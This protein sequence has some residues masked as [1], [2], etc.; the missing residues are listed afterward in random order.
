MSRYEHK[1]WEKLRTY[2]RSDLSAYNWVSKQCQAWTWSLSRPSRIKT[3]LRIFRDPD[4]KRLS[5]AYPTLGNSF[6]KARVPVH[7]EK[8][9]GMKEM[10]TNITQ[11]EVY[12]MTVSAPNP[13]SYM[14]CQGNQKWLWFCSKLLFAA[15]KINQ[16]VMDQVFRKPVSTYKYNERSHVT[17]ET[18]R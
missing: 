10:E 18:T 9:G 16:Y 5:A 14:I 8:E 12:Q 1:M 6:L 15:D 17:P 13:T 11:D 2:H 4:R 3:V 7:L